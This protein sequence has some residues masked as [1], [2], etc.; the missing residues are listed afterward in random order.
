MPFETGDTGR[1]S[2]WA[3]RIVQSGLHLH[4]GLP[5]NPEGAPL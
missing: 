1:I 3:Q 5:P 4:I 2:P